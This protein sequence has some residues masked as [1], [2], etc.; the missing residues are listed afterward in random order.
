MYVTLRCLLLSTAAI[1]GYQSFAT[2]AD[3]ID[4]HVG[5]YRLA[6]G[7]LV[8]IGPTDSEALRWRRFDG[9]VGALHPG[10]SGEWHSAYGWT[11]REDGIIATFSP[12]DAGEIDFAGIKGR[13]VEFDVTN[14]KFGSHE[15]ELAGR[16]VMPKGLRS[17]PIVV[18]VHGAEHD[19]ALTFNFL[20]RLLPAEGVGVFV[21]DKRGTGISGGS[22]SQ[23]FTLLADD[24]V[25]AMR[26][27]RRLGGS[28]VSRVGYQGASQ[29][30]WVAPIAA[31]Q[32]P[33]DFVIVSFGLAV[34]V[35]DEDQQEIA[36]EMHDKGHSP[37][38]IAKAQEVGRAVEAVAASGFTK[39]FEEL[40]VVRARYQHEPWYKDVHGNF[41]YFFL[42]HSEAELRAMA[43]EFDWGTPFDYDPMP[44]LRANSTA[45]LW[46]LGGRDYEAPAV[47]TSRRI[48]SL[49]DAGRPFTL[50]LYP[51]AEHGMT[52]FEMSAD[53]ERVS[54]RYAIGYFRMM[55]DFARTGRLLGVYGDAEISRTKQP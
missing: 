39:G 16:L 17:V 19:S 51:Y 12:C 8:D 44:T 49:I 34:S 37:E 43:K 46:I 22:Y 40:D 55:R 24:A 35:N 48:Q 50:A 47:E 38:E 29:G 6:D 14:T 26:E 5:S 15:T 3:A 23:D 54:T 36:M 9:T 18:L 10:P 1:F 30:G 45:Q 53:G 11:K 41:T 21:Y 32:A 20:Q 31:N 2:A 52:L 4:C 13:R 28:R 42:P 33:V 27:A 7:S 25:A